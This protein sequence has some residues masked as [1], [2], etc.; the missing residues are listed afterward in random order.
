M[1]SMPALTTAASYSSPVA[2]P[3]AFSRASR[4]SSKFASTLIFPT[5]KLQRQP[6]MSSRARQR[7]VLATRGPYSRSAFKTAR[8]AS[9]GTVTEPIS[10]IFFLPSFCFSSSLRLRETSP[11]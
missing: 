11:P 7:L 1:P 5:R 3:A 8:K 9:C 2:R 4:S 10:F 6:Q